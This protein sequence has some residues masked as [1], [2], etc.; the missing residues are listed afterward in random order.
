MFKR[1]TEG[2]GPSA[3]GCSA[4]A[5]FYT[6]IVLERLTRKL[7][8]TLPTLYSGGRTIVLS[9]L[10]YSA[11][12]G[13][14][15]AASFAYYAF[16]SLF[17]LILLLITFGSFFFGDGEAVQRGVLTLVEN[18]YPLSNSER[19]GIMRIVG[20]FIEQRSGAGL[21]AIL[22]LIWASL[23][24]FHA[25]VRGVNRA[26]GTKEYSWWHLPLQNLILVLVV[27]F[28]L[29]IG[30]AASFVYVT[31][32]KY[33]H[34]LGLPPQVLE[35]I[36]AFAS[37][38]R[39]VTFVVL[40]V[41]LVCF[42][43]LAP[44]KH[45]RFQFVWGP[46]IFSTLLLQFLQFLFELYATNVANFNAIYGAFGGAVALLMWVYLSGSIIIFGGCLSAILAE[47][48]GLSPQEAS[49]EVEES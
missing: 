39:L 23:R 21:L 10:R 12:D 31:V 16:L 48:K 34:Q 1:A 44:R 20:G 25:L 15:R 19:L 13:E 27:G 37:A 36:F 28:S 6:A 33:V 18:V 35:T 3:K 42:Y 46:A 43:K 9:V 5:R 40:S 41:G 14:Q 38:K 29:L 24:F 26:W 11:I 8:Q 47:K 49:S 17:P 45:P 7:Q 4:A 2:G 30:M 32:E 22:G